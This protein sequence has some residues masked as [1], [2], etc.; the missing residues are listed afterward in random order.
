[1]EEYKILKN[2]K[3][4]FESVNENVEVEGIVYGLVNINNDYAGFL[5]DPN[6]NDCL[7]FGGTSNVRG[8]ALLKYS[9][10]LEKPIIARGK[11]I[12]LEK[13]SSTESSVVSG[14]FLEVHSFEFF[15]YK[16]KIPG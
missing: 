7:L 2:I 10:R 6:K 3:Q 13:I 15:D 9:E 8:L 11:I 14:K 1:M 5:E 4:A 16:T 12:D